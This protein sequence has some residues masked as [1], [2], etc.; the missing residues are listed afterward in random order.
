MSVA[1]ESHRACTCSF[2]IYATASTS[3]SPKNLILLNMR[4]WARLMLRLIELQKLLSTHAEFYHWHLWT[5]SS[6]NTTCHIKSGRAA[7]CFPADFSELFFIWSRAHVGLE[8]V[9]LLLELEDP[10]IPLDNENWSFTLNSLS[11]S[12]L[13]DW[14]E[15]ACSSAL[16]LVLHIFDNLLLI[17]DDLVQAVNDS[18]VVLGH[19][20]LDL[21]EALLLLT[22]PSN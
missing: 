15:P 17:A 13:S 3:T 20:I 10:L 18:K 9:A 7:S 6:R 1:N 2:Q 11:V 12:F 14:S 16:V 8:E 19:A 22:V 21:F 4:F 5:W